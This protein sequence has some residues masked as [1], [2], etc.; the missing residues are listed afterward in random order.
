[1]DL[2]MEQGLVEEVR[3]LGEM[4]LTEDSISMKGIG[5]KE[6][7]GFLKGEYDLEEAARLIKRNTRRYA[8]RQLTWLRRDGE[9][10]WLFREDCPDETGALDEI[11]RVLRQ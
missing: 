10:H 4:G 11:S 7:F 9:L 1:V 3:K 8:K 6:V 5:Y 2:L